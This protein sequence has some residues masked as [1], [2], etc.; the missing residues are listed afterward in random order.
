MARPVFR[1][2]IILFGVF[3]AIW[4]GIRYLLPLALPFLIGT[5]LALVADP[6]VRL[7][8]NRL[9]LPRGA[10]AGIGV[11]VTLLLTVSLLII[12]AALLVRELSALAGVLPNL[13]RKSVV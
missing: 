7:C 6:L 3:L 5:G 4:L 1:K 12:L 2:F 9:H 11:S 10:A 13:D 8:Q